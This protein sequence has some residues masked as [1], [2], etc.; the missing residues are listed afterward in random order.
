[1]YQGR[2]SYEALRDT[3]FWIEDKVNKMTIKQLLVNII[4]LVVGTGFAYWA[5]KS[6]YDFL[7]N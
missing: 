7:I 5:C 1:M 2:E 6:Y 4:V 3:F